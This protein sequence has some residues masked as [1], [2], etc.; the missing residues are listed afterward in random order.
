MRE[1]VIKNVK[2]KDVIYFTIIIL[3][4]Q[5]V[6]KWV[7]SLYCRK[8]GKQPFILIMRFHLFFF[9]IYICLSISNS[10]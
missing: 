9:L 1:N 5:M 4:L 8:G 2:V 3:I 10:E 7:S 6:C